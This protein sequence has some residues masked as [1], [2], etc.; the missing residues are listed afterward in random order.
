M[1][2]EQNLKPF[3]K[4][5]KRINRKGRPKSFDAMRALAQTVSHEAVPL[6]DKQGNPT[7]EQMTVIE[8]ILRQWAQSKDPRLQ[9]A[10]V[11]IAYGK[12]AQQH[13]L[14]GKDGGAIEVIHV[15]PKA[16]DD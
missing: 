4:G 13:E 11:E 3:T 12:V 2:N 16:E 7:G 8:A 1:A 5:D 14:T 10:F 15:K 6:K 9:I